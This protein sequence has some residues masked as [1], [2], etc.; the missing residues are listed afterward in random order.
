[1]IGQ[2]YDIILTANATGDGLF[3]INATVLTGCSWIH[4]NGTIQ[5]IL[6]YGNDTDEIPVNQGLPGSVPRDNSCFDEPREKL[7]PVVQKTVPPLPPGISFPLSTSACPPQN[8]CIPGILLLNT[9]TN[10]PIISDYLREGLKWNIND[11][12][13]HGYWL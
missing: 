11:N 4:N 3:W 6:Y 10:G 7:I 2:R 13:L 1:M 12:F 8:Q 5:G 9:T